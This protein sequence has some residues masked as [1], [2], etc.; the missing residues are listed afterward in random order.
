MKEIFVLFFIIILCS[1]AN[2]FTET[3]S[4]Y[5]TEAFVEEAAYSET[6]GNYTTRVYATQMPVSTDIFNNFITSIGDYG[7]TTTA[8]PPITNPSMNSDLNSAEAPAKINFTASFEEGTLPFTYVWDFAD[9]N[10]TILPFISSRSSIISHTFTGSGVFNVKVTVYDNGGQSSSAQW[11]V[12]L[13]FAGIT[14][15]IIK[16]TDLKINPVEVKLR[17]TMQIAV[18]VKKLSYS[19]SNVTVTVTTTD[20]KGVQVPGTLTLNSTAQIPLNTTK[21]FDFNYLVLPS[22]KENQTYYIKA[23]AS[24]AG[25]GSGQTTDNT[26]TTRFTVLMKV[27]NLPPLPEIEL[28]LLPLVA[29]VIVFLLRRQ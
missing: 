25:E 1:L 13:T 17:D 18:L 24:S 3:Y 23:V 21:E 8:G 26:L 2:A 29:L 4:N 10:I 15:N 7:D 11:T 14:P 6:Y 12:T 16:M 9:G 22:L 19:D 28:F 27:R 5:T 20:D